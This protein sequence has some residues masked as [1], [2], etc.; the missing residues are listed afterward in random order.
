MNQF[1]KYQHLERFGTTEVQNIELGTVYIFPKID[2][3]NASLWHD[4]IQMCAGSRNR[5]LSLDN[6]NGGFLNWSLQQ[7]N[8]IEFFDQNRFIRLY[9]EW[10]IPHSLKTYRKDAWRKFYV[11]DVMID[12]EYIAFDN[13]YKLLDEYGI[14]WIPPLAKVNH[15]TYEKLIEYM[16]GNNYLIEDGKGAGEGIVIKNYD[17]KNRFGRTV[18]AKIVTSEFR[19]KHIKEMGASYVNM[20]PPVEQLIADEFVTEAL[21]EKVYSKIENES[22]FTSRQI[23]Q[24]LNTVFY[25]LVREDS[26]TFIK[27]HKNPT[28]NFGMLQSITFKK[29]KE[30][31]A[32]LF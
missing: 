1:E 8:L 9:G 2:G 22:G 4:G 21:V 27:K 10:L 15:C 30:I 12:G 32:E 28:V 19:E 31:K 5:Q 17:F 23:P 13:Y 25:D 26:W 20:K 14:D 7:D 24:L 18:W 3:T 16:N 29:V 11:F 6:D